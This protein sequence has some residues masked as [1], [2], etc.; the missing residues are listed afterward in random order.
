VSKPLHFP[1]EPPL[2]KLRAAGKV[3]SEEELER[4]MIEASEADR[5]ARERRLLSQIPERYRHCTIDSWQGHPEALERVAGWNPE[6]RWCLVLYSTDNGVGK[7]HLATARWR[8]LAPALRPA[9]W[10]SVGRLLQTIYAQFGAGFDDRDHHVEN[11]ISECKLLLLDDLGRQHRGSEDARARL[12][13]MLCERYDWKR[14]TV[15]TTNLTEEQ[16]AKWDPALADRI[17]SSESVIVGRQG[18][19]WRRR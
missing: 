16:M 19:S 13:T 5:E 18:E 2:E 3:I 11:R 15:I 6:Q 12:V 14:A 8:E 4:Q 17:Y 10:Q 9:I 7:T 1:K